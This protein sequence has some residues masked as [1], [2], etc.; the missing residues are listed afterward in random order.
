[1]ANIIG[2]STFIDKNL[3]E[4]FEALCKEEGCTVYSKLAELIEAYV[5]SK[6]KIKKNEKNSET[7]NK[8]E[9]ENVWKEW[10]W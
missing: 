4:A 2:V 6:I 5:E 1:M 9:E 3:K 10:G 8:K 7:E